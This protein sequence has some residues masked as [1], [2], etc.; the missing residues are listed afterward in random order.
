V[1]FFILDLRSADVDGAVVPARLTLAT[2]TLDVL[3]RAPYVV[4]MVHGFNVDRATGTAELRALSRLLPCVGPGAAVAVLWPGDCSVG[5][6]SYPFETNKADDSSVELAK[7]IGDQ[8]PQ[9]PRIAFIAHSLGSRM[10]MQTVNQLRI[11]SVPVDQVCLMAGA[12]D[13][14]SL[15]SMAEYRSAS[16]YAS[17]IAALSSVSDRVLKFAYPAGNLLSAFIHWTRTTNA[18]LGYQ[19]PRAAAPPNGDIPRQV[20]SIV[21]PQSAGVDH[22]DYLPNASGPADPRQLAAAACANQV[23]RGD[24]APA[25][26]L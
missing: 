7:F 2:P 1:D 26:S 9:R 21:I 4:F 6:L 5:P 24:A 16:T 15:A 18:A 14:D 12:I 17:R 19:G 22:G 20:C 10:V 25:Y 3:Q 23:L 11:M 8:L 13:G